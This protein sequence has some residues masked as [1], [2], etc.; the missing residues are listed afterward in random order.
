MLEYSLIKQHQPRFNVRLRDDKSYP[1]LAVTLDDEWPRPMVMRG[2]KRKG[3]RYFGPYGHAY[4]IRETL[5]L[6]LR[7]FPLRTCSRQQVRPPPAA[8]PALPAVPHREVLRPVRRR[9]RQGRL[10]PRWSRSCSSSST[11]T[12]TRSCSRL[13]TEMHEAADALEF[14]R[15][16]RLRDRLTSVHKAIEK[17]QM[18]G[19]RATRTSTS[20]A[21]PTTS[22]R[23]R[24]R[25]SSCA[26]AG[27]SG[28]KGFIVDKV[29]DLTPAELVG[30]VLEQLYDDPPERRP[31]A[32][33][34]PG[35]A[36]RPRALRGV[37]R[38]QLR[39]SKVAVRV[40]QR[41]DKRALQE[42]VTRNAAEEFDP[43]PAAPGVR[44]QQPGPGP[45]RAAGASSA[46]PT[47]RCASSAT[48]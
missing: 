1:F 12:P 8:G 4:A 24:C 5:D 32:G 11:A 17:Q 2:R 3:V 28:R 16:A 6:L 14:E 20:S 34:G 39:G 45:Q 43:P 7:T 29:E 9:G 18:V 41:G 22:S 46:C 47:P 35:R 31:E 21:S 38:R 19:R 30:R 13:E 36:R 40:P 25:S 37:A 44:P 42:T 23:P 26:R 33:A 48:T 27:S 10:R 15:A